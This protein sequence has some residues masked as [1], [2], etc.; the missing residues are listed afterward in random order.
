[1]PLARRQRR[2]QPWEARPA[3]AGPIRTQDT[4]IK[5]AHPSR[6]P[7]GRTAVFLA[8]NCPVRGHRVNGGPAGR[9]TGS[10]TPTI[11]TAAHS[12]GFGT[13]QEDGQNQDYQS[14]RGQNI[15]SCRTLG[16]RDE[17]WSADQ[18]VLG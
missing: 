5:A 17:D 11:G 12:Q 1:V 4:L 8:P 2:A 7:V 3:H 10:A 6:V 16:F 14:R 15:R 18:N 9:R 13:Y